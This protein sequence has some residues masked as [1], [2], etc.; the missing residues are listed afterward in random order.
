MTGVSV[1][2]WSLQFGS[3]TMLS[4]AVETFTGLL[5]EGVVPRFVVPTEFRKTFLEVSESLPWSSDFVMLPKGTRGQADSVNRA[6]RPEDRQRP[7]WIFNCDSRIRPGALSRRDLTGNSLVCTSL[8]GDHWSFVS[9]DSHG[10]VIQ[11]AEKTRISGWCSTG[12]YC[13]ESAADFRDAY[14]STD[15]GAQE[16]YVAPV[17]N[18]LIASNRQVK[19]VAI[20]PDLFD[21]FGTPTELEAFC[22]RNGLISPLG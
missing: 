21:V 19:M 9:I 18:T 7:L 8:E 22:S 17:Y 11:V 6:L 16:H 1:P 12:L 14:S 15:F 13:F 3:R 2:K 4:W 5:D 20:D 10:C